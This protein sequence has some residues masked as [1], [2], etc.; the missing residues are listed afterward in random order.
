[1]RKRYANWVAGVAALVGTVAWAGHKSPGPVV[2]TS[3]GAHGSLGTA[4]NSTDTIQYIACTINVYSGSSPYVSCFAN[5]ASTG[6][7]YVSCYSYDANLVNAARAITGDSY[8][9]F[10]FNTS[11]ICTSLYVMNGSHMDPKKP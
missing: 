5:E 6:Y 8:I 10:Q 7:A 1:M 4:R 2:V 11:G 9:Q 3:S